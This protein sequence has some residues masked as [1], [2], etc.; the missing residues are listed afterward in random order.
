MVD[1]VMTSA[2]CGAGKEGSRQGLEEY[3]NLKLIDMGGL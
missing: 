3:S 1:V 2:P